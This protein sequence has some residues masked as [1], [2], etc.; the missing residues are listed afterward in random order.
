MQDLRQVKVTRLMQEETQWENLR[1]LQKDTI[2]QLHD[3]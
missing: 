1:R 3:A 2:G